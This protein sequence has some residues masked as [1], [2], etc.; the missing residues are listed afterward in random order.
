MR[1]AGAE[2]KVE[3]AAVAEGKGKGWKTEETRCQWMTARSLSLFPS[4]SVAVAVAMPWF[5]RSLF[6]AAFPAMVI[7]EE[8]MAG[9]SR[10]LCHCRP[11]W[12]VVVDARV[13]AKLPT[14][15]YLPPFTYTSPSS[16][17]GEVVR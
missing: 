4:L 8:T 15:L 12:S 17:C 6:R 2:T 3:G 1:G 11:C 13:C 16:P 9:R 10:C 5:L 14:E 7:A